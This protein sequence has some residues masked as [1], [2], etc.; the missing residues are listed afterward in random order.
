MTVRG[1]ADAKAKINKILQRKLQ[2]GNRIDVS[3][4]RT[5]NTLSHGSAKRAMSNAKL[6]DE[7]C[8]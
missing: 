7:K 1:K 3:A 4:R 8:E 5:V 2:I 6:E